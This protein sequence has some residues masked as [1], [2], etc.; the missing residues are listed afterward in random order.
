MKM[1]GVTSANGSYGISENPYTVAGFGF[2]DAFL[3]EAPKGSFTFNRKMISKDPFVYDPE[4]DFPFDDRDY[5][6]GAILYGN[7]GFGFERARL[8]NYSISCGI[9]EIPEIS[10]QFEVLG[11]VGPHII[12]EVDPTE[13]V[14]MEIPSQGSIKVTCVPTGE[15]EIFSTNHVSNF[16]Y[17]RSVN[18]EEVYALPT[19]TEEMWQS[20]EPID[21]SNT[22]PIQVDIVDPIEVD[23]S[24]SIVVND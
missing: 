4:E 6:S 17:E 15:G 18:L 10:V 11:D 3:S 13:S 19:G 7:K 22:F 14:P 21:L 8:T 2:V 24:F 16:R 1:E 20:D 9:D 5:F 12:P 23:I